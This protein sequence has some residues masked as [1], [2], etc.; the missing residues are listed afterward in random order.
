VLDSTHLAATEV[1]PFEVN[2][3]EAGEGDATSQVFYLGNSPRLIVMRYSGR[4]S[5]VSERYFLG[6][7]ADFVVERDE[8]YYDR[9]VRGEVDP[10]P[11]IVSRVPSTYYFCGGRFLQG[12][13]RAIARL[14]VTTRD[15]VLKV[16][17]KG[18]RRPASG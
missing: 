9:P 7:S 3:D 8:V 1:R 17:R 14:M 11:E 2:R 18:A 16:I 10:P 4:W 6:D 12:G 13:E 15:R 5:K